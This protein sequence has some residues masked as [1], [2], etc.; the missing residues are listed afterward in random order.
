MSPLWLLWIEPPPRANSLRFWKDA[1][2]LTGF[3]APRRY[4]GLLHRCFA[5]GVFH[6]SAQ[7]FAPV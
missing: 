6:E 3:V 7:L 2:C 1:A 4:S 5:F